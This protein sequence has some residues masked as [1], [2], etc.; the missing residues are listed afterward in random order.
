[1][2]SDGRRFFESTFNTSD[3]PD[4]RSEKVYLVSLQLTIA[5]AAFARTKNGFRG[6]PETQHSHENRR[7]RL[8]R[9]PFPHLIRRVRFRR[10]A[11]CGSCSRRLLPQRA[12]YARRQSPESF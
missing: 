9:R 12:T 6:R 11:A 5:N 4:Y 8:C 10:V 2:Y 1:M 7:F 3:D